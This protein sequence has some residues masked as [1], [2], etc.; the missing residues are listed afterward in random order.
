MKIIFCIGKYEFII[1]F[2]GKIN[3]VYKKLSLMNKNFKFIKIIQF[4]ST[5]NIDSK[6][7]YIVDFKRKF[8]E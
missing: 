7:M 6:Q 1:R 5:S 4:L 8:W 3:S 2:L